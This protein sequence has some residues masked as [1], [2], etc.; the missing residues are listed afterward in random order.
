VSPGA[1][2][3]AYVRQMR[4]RGGGQ[5]V[6]GHARS[7]SQS[8]TVSSSSIPAYT[9]GAISRAQRITGSASASAIPSAASAGPGAGTS[10]SQGSLHQTPVQNAAHIGT[11]TTRA[12]AGRGGRQASEPPPAPVRVTRS[13]DE[14]IG[15]AAGVRPHD[16]GA[17]VGAAGA[18]PAAG[19]PTTRRR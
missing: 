4:A 15:I 9:S 2:R 12:G 6:Q 14:R 5:T 1:Q 11:T 16:T 19:G 3:S 7:Q 8:Q 13:R 17:G 18:A 10:G